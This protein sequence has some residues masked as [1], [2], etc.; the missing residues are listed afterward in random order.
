MVTGGR[1]GLSLPRLAAYAGDALPEN[2]S[3]LRALLSKA[4]LTLEDTRNAFW[5]GLLGKGILP[6]GC[7][8][9][10][11]ELDTGLE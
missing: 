10:V 1:I 3:R 5:A 2:A 6:R 11:Q 9:S 8:E 4:Y 7:F